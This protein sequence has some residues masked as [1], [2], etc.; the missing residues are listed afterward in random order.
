MTAKNVTA[1]PGSIIT[2]SGKDGGGVVKLRSADTT[3]LR[4]SIEVVGEAESAKGGKVQLLGEKVGM[5][6]SAKVDASGGAGG[7]E[8]L[9]GGDYLGKNPNVPNAKAVVLGSEA[10][11]IS[12]ATSNGNGGRVI[13]WS[14]EYT[15]FYGDIS[16]QG[17]ISGG[18]GGFVETSSKVNLQAFGSGNT[19]A[20]FGL[21]G[22]WLLDPTDVT[23]TA[24]TTSGMSNLGPFL[25]QEQHPQEIFGIRRQ[26]QHN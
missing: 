22:E 12:D 10:K 11:I 19:Y 17:G 7:G 6:E 8:V 5:F 20:P 2:A 18:D 1:D 26:I 23:I 15:G 24:A 21:P 14:D 3:I 16:A 4:G 13:L 25:H 9:V